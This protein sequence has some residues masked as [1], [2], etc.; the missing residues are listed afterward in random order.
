M[1]TAAFALLPESTSPARGTTAKRIPRFFWRLNFNPRPPCGGRPEGSQ[2]ILSFY[3]FQSTSPAWGTTK[4]IQ[5]SRLKMIFQSTSPVRGTTIKSIYNALCSL[6][7]NPRPPCGGRP[8]DFSRRAAEQKI[9]IHVPRAGDDR[10]YVSR[11]SDGIIISIH[12]PRAG[13]DKAH[14]AKCGDGSIFQSTSPVRGT[15]HLI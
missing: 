4:N 10:G 12:V 6:Y 15:T 2:V 5:E 9:S 14:A 11:K 1:Q 8:A 3:V 7:F 13:D